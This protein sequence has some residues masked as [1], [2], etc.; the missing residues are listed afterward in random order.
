MIRL[1][2]Q[3]SKTVMCEENYRLSQESECKGSSYRSILKGA[4]KGLS[5][6]KG[7]LQRPYVRAIKIVTQDRAHEF[8]T[9]FA[10]NWSDLPLIVDP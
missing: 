1:F 4:F 2:A 9:L 7:F 6:W 3:Q 8:F 5:S 10:T